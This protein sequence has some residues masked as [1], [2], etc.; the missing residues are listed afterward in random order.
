MPDIS[1]FS[2]VGSCQGD[3]E[4]LLAAALTPGHQSDGG[5][6]IVHH[7]YIKGCKLQC[8]VRR[9]RDSWHPTVCLSLLALLCSMPQ[10]ILKFFNS[11]FS[12]FK[13]ENIFILSSY[14]NFLLFQMQLWILCDIAIRTKHIKQAGWWRTWS[15]SGTPKRAG[16]CMPWDFSFYA[17][18]VSHSR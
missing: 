8:A 1:I 17:L 18:S 11:F 12:A 9:R 4:T 10:L 6:D 3:I 13:N 5:A 7:I 16:W 2:S 15:I 14:F